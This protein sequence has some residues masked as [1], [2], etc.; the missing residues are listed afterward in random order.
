MA[1]AIFEKL[2]RKNK[3][4]VFLDQMEQVVSWPE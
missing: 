3:R 4:E 1:L 2:R